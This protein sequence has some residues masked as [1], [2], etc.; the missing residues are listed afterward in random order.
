MKLVNATPY[1]A[2]LLRTVVDDHRLFGAV[3]VRI[4][5]DIVDGRLR[6]SDEQR[7]L[8]S[9][10]AWDGPWGPM[11]ADI[12]PVRGGVDVMI[13]G[14]ARAPGGRP[15][16][17]IDV[18]A[19]IGSR[20][21]ARITAWGERRW[22]RSLGGLV[23]SEPEPLSE[24]PLTLERAYGGSDEWDGITVP[25]TDN[26]AGRGFHLEEPRAHGKPLPN[27][28]DPHAPIS[29]W[30]DRPEPVGTVTCAQNFGPRARRGL[31]LADDKQSIRR[32]LPRFFN[33]AFP[34]MVAPS[35]VARDHVI[36]RGVR[37][38]G[39]LEFT[40]PDDPLRVDVRIG[41]DG[42]VRTPTIDQ[43]GVEPDTRRVFL[44]YRY[45]FRYVMTPH[46]RRSCRLSLAPAT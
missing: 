17:R 2:R 4:S 14:S 40:L 45:A 19:E 7:W 31:E 46:E 37:G 39:P 28:E 3:V 35:A 15:A 42:G 10:G 25:F 16:P 38:D 18:V 22:K 12:P 33:D 29:R 8:V 23:A 20:W 43:I 27:L 36:V 21:R 30:D 41:D 11:P 32:V 5:H 34:G 9:A 6:P 26:P 13:F 24:V 1:P 44:A